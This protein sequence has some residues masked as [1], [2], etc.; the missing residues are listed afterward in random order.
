MCEVQLRYFTGTGVRA[1]Q[2]QRLEFCKK[3]VLC[4]PMLRMVLHMGGCMCAMLMRAMHAPLLVTALAHWAQLL[5]CRGP[6][7][8]M[9]LGHGVI[10]S[11]PK[12]VQ[13][14]QAKRI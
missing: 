11:N 2:Q 5:V 14:L 10:Q 7:C 6:P 13:T 4:C 8:A 12:Q 3:A 1:C 9:L